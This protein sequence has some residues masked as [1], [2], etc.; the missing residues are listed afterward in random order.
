MK[1]PFSAYAGDDS[2]STPRIPTRLIDYDAAYLAYGPFSLQG[3][4]VNVTLDC[5]DNDYPAG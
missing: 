5:F 1:K 4:P 2:L 3:L